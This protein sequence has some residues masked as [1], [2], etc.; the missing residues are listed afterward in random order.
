MVKDF[1]RT[2]SLL[3]N[4]KIIHWD[5]VMFGSRI[6]ECNRFPRLQNFSH[7]ELRISIYPLEYLY[8]SSSIELKQILHFQNRNKMY[9]FYSEPAILFQF[10]LFYQKWQKRP[11]PLYNLF[12]WANF[13]LSKCSYLFE[14]WFFRKFINWTCFFI[15]ASHSKVKRK[16]LMISTPWSEL[17]CRNKEPGQGAC[18][19]SSR[20]N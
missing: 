13:L 19:W 11:W 14:R 3:G 18:S 9:L 16:K 17:M 12:L 10:F 4:Y 5:N 15:G 6:Q 1:Q 2:M 8:C 7:L 20:L